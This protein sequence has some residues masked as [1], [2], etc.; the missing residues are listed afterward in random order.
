[1]NERRDPYAAR[2][3][4]Q[5][6]VSGPRVV[7]IVRRRPKPVPWLDRTDTWGFQALMWIA[8]VTVLALLFAAAVKR[9]LL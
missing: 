2:E 6:V 3:T 8:L 4:T 7:T 9:G 5:L 1:M